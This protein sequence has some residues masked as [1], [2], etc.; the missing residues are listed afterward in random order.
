MDSNTRLFIGNLASNVKQKHLKEV[1]GVYGT[2]VDVVRQGTIGILTFS[3]PDEM[4][5]ALRGEAGRLKFDGRPTKI[6]PYR[7]MVTSRRIRKRSLSPDSRISEEDSRSLVYET[8]EF[9]PATSDSKDVLI[10][11]VDS[12]DADYDGFVQRVKMRIQDA[13]FWY[14]HYAFR[15]W[16]S[17]IYGLI[18]KTVARD[19]FWAVIYIRPFPV[20]LQ[21]ISRLD[22]YENNVIGDSWKT[23]TTDAV[24]ARLT[25]R[26]AGTRAVSPVKIKADA[27]HKT[28]AS[29]QYTDASIQPEA[30]SMQDASTQTDEVSLQPSNAASDEK[31]LELNFKIDLG[32][33]CHGNPG[34]SMQI[35]S[36]ISVLTAVAAS[37][38]QQQPVS[39]TQLNRANPASPF[40]ELLSSLTKK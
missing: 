9:Q 28:K 25:E 13:D 5:L 30:V 27:E 22:I 2:I 7:D 31:K 11:S 1:F 32:Q 21:A 26:R 38:I 15:S 24:L 40:D 35:Q 29:K 17:A 12:S 20:R 18:A 39:P 23:V 8:D 10:V 16:S 19:N 4:Q 3:A 6:E 36:L 14:H 34:M 33:L 37:N